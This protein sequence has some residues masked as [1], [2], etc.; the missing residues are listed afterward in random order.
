MSCEVT[1]LALAGDR[2]SGV[3]VLVAVTT[4]G[5]LSPSFD[6]VGD[7]SCPRAITLTE[8]AHKKIRKRF[9]FTSSPP[10]S[11]EGLGPQD[12]GTRPALILLFAKKFF[13]TR[14]RAHE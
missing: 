7:G 9:C 14:T 13:R 10:V 3:S 1:T 11:R 12:A 4:T 6:G 5:S 2:S 8:I